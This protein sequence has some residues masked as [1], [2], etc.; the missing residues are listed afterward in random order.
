[1][2]PD[3]TLAYELLRGIKPEVCPAGCVVAEE[4][5]GPGPD[6]FVMSALSKAYAPFLKTINETLEENYKF[7]GRYLQI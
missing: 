2:T 3:T 4:P 6:P 1:M 7:V 5:L